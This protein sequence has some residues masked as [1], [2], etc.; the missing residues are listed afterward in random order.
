MAEEARLASRVVSWAKTV[1]EKNR[2][3]EKRKD[4]PAHREMLCGELIPGL[5]ADNFMTFS[6]SQFVEQAPNVRT[7]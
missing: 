3:A 2:K 5:L 4:H 1:K 6:P 7:P